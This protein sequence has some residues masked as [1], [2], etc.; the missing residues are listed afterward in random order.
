VIYDMSKE[1]RALV[2]KTSF[3]CNM[4]FDMF[5]NLLTTQ[6]DTPKCPI[7]TT[8]RKIKKEISRING[9]VDAAAAAKFDRPTSIYDDELVEKRDWATRVLS[10]FYSFDMD[11]SKDP[12]QVSGRSERKRQRWKPRAREPSEGARAKRGCASQAR[13]REPTHL[14]RARSPTK[15]EP[16]LANQSGSGALAN[17][18]GTRAR[19]PSWLGPLAE[20]RL[21][22]KD[23]PSCGAGCFAW[24][25]SGPEPPQQAGRGARPSSPSTGN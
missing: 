16:A 22:I 24:G 23:V 5:L 10:D 15:L 3:E 1:D 21:S 9:L 6:S 8:R 12:P 7:C 17:Q 2:F 4:D 11:T 14:K 20:T 25:L 19:Q 13:A 18:V